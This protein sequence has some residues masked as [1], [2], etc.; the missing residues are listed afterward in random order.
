[1]AMKYC[2]GGYMKTIKITNLLMSLSIKYV[3]TYVFASLVLACTLCSLA[4]GYKQDT[5]FF[6]EQAFSFPLAVLSYFSA[7]TIF[8]VNFLL[9]LLKEIELP[10]R[11]AL[12]KIANISWI[13]PIQAVI[14]FFL[15][16]FNLFQAFATIFSFMLLSST[17]ALLAVAFSTLLVVLIYYVISWLIHLN[18][19]GEKYLQE[20]ENDK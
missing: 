8:F 18:E 7:L 3:V 14:L 11:Q 13:I 1:M 9:E 16:I 19:L 15:S 10:V 17:V 12:K 4:G 20:K 5:L 2:R 6:V